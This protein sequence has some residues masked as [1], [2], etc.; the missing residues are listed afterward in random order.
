[1]AKKPLFRAERLEVVYDEKHWRL[2]HRLRAE[3]IEIMRVLNG[4]RIFSIV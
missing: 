4:L 2:L 1:M 3:A